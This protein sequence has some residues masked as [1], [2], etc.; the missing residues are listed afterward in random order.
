MNNLISDALLLIGALFLLLAAIGVLRMPDLLTR[1]QAA[2]KASTLAIA[3]I[4]LAAA[5]HFSDLVV[6]TRALAVIAFF[7][8]TAPVTAHL[9]ARASYS[10]GTPLWHGT[11]IDELGQKKK[12]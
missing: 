12:S 10:V 3:C 7:F 11:V 9:I 6:T 4:M 8:L 5:V 2:T 1:M